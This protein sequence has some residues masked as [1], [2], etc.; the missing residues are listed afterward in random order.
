MAK[1]TEEKT[2]YLRGGL[3]LVNGN[4][5]I[6]LFSI[7]GRHIGKLTA[8]HFPFEKQKG[9]G[10][11]THVNQ[12]AQTPFKPVSLH[13]HT[14][15]HTHTQK[16]KKKKHT[17]TRAYFFLA[18]LRLSSSS[19]VRS[20][21]GGSS[22]LAASFPPFLAFLS[23][24]PGFGAADTDK[25]KRHVERRQKTNKEKIGEKRGGACR[26]ARV[27]ALTLLVELQDGVHHFFGVCQVAVL[28][29]Q[30]VKLLQNRDWWERTTQ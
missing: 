23:P 24:E 29:W 1:Q 3:E 22:A 28:L 9:R 19:S 12:S 20:A 6:T 2:R 26:V 25:D 11:P 4:A 13:T 7:H 16:K 21:S 8:L 10:T 14:H 27:D 5:L 17:H 18:I 30:N 15:T